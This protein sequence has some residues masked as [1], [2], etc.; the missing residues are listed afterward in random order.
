MHYHRH[1]VVELPHGAD[2]I[3]GDDRAGMNS[4]SLS[5]GCALN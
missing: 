1:A 4:Q 5:K 2:G 3:P